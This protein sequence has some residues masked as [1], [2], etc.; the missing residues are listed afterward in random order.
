MSDAIPIYQPVINGLIDTIRTSGDLAKAKKAIE[1]LHPDSDFI[2]S[3]SKH[4]LDCLVTGEALGRSLI[5]RKDASMST[6]ASIS[7]KDSSLEWTALDDEPVNIAFDVI[8]EAAL[9]LL[10]QKSLSISG[11]EDQELRDAVRDKIAEAIEKGMTFDEFEA[12]M[13]SIF[14]SYGVTRLSP[15]HV[16]LVFRMNVF[17]AYN[18]GMAQEISE[19][20][21]RFPL[22]YFSPIHDSRSRHIPLQGYYPTDTIPIPPIDYNCRCSVRYIHVSQITGNE[23]PQYVVPPR[24]D[25]I[26]FDQR[27]G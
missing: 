23:E 19:M 11:V 24:P 3:L 17:S 27:T 25:L 14:D 4:I 1:A 22:A 7:G 12:G 18:K 13:D 5:V 8:P 6:D 2:K 21:D 16:E 20:S 10:R 15:H 26:K 9:E